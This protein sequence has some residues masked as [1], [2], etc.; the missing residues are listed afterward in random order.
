M[1]VVGLEGRRE[2]RHT[3]LC[4]RVPLGDRAQGPNAWKAGSSGGFVGWG[5][6]ASQLCWRGRLQTGHVPG[7]LC[8]LGTY[9]FGTATEPLPLPP[10]AHGRWVVTQKN[11]GVQHCPSQVCGLCLLVGDIACP[12]RCLA[13]RSLSKEWR[14]AAEMGLAEDLC[15]ILSNHM[16][17]HSHQ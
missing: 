8:L 11:M 14:W 5:H 15:F 16:V 12:L 2:F 9:I 4:E 7:W 1:G 10:V 17:V 13:W 6:A 3:V